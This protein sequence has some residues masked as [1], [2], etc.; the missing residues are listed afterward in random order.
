[1]TA[2]TAPERA[3]PR[4]GLGTFGGVFTPSILTI[5]GVIMYL[6]FGW[7]VGN[8]G[9]RN[10]LIIVT[11]ATSITLLTG[12]SIAQIATDQVVRTGG[13]YYMV[14]RSLG[15]EIGGA[16]GIPL[17]FAQALSVA[18]YT[19]GFAESVNVVAPD[20]PV[21]PL[22]LGTTVA[23]TVLALVSA[24]TAI[25]AQYFIMAAIALSLVSFFVGA[26]NGDPISSNV[27]FE[28]EPFWEVFAVFF[29][30]VT[31]IMAGVN[32]SGDLADPRR[33]I[34][35]G[36]LAAI[37]VSFVV[38]MVIPV[39][40][41]R[42]ANANALVDDPLVMRQ[43]SFWGPAILLGVW[44]ATL[45]SAL[46]S[47][48]GAPRILQALARDDILP[49]P[50]KILGRGSGP[51]DEPRVGT[52]VSLALA[53]A[54]VAI[55]DLNAV[56]P[57]L[58][59]FFL[60]SYAVVNIVSAGE[61]FL[62]SP[63]FRPTFRVH[64]SVSLL[65]A[66]ACAG[67]MFLIDAIATIVA[68]AVVTV[69]WVLLNRRRAR[70]RWGDMR[71][72]LWLTVVRWSAGK[73]RPSTHAKAWRPNILVLAGSPTKRWNLIEI[74]DAWSHGRGLLTVATIVPDGTPA[75]RKR[76]LAETVREH[77]AERR[78]TALVRVVSAPSPYVGASVLVEAYGL[79]GIVPNTVVLG[80]GDT[81]ADKHDYAAMVHGLHD[82]GRNVIMVRAGDE[83]WGHGHRRID[84]WLRSMRDNGAL[85][86]T[87]ANTLRA[88]RRW[89]G[90]TVHVRMVVANEA[91]V[92]E[93]EANLRSLLTLARLDVEVDVTV[94]DRPV[95]QVI[96]EGGADADLTLIG[97]PDPCTDPDGFAGR[98]DA[99]V[100]AIDIDS[101]IAF[102]LASSDVDLEELLV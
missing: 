68:I 3:E 93:V 49:R 95:S 9:L 89:R 86:I 75:Q 100:E 35:R 29:P 5:L 38:Y 11:I 26:R 90:A 25:R 37:G 85:M 83:G 92:Q 69:I 56:A 102:V 91:A 73:V 33:S 16:I 46:G 2:S 21:R 6:R 99:F 19:L 87:L 94:D 1:M 40:L 54:V 8:A 13:A 78:V 20:I 23:V 53:L 43:L 64:W 41:D 58:T 60:A 4:P 57:V 34:P 28:P 24:K 17:Y 97:L 32:L 55:G 31:G 42:G 39:V 67:V 66:V 72:G 45:S 30:A 76:S 63:S 15:T 96:N 48:L 44:G 77:L 27:P 84:V 88:D 74:A 47:I 62:R 61:R 59:M 71:Q 7:V 101:P 82:A 51:A 10:T 12:L 81:T 14:S 18:L 80:D 70:A 65:G 52:F 79:G 22:A 50:L 98:L 36:T